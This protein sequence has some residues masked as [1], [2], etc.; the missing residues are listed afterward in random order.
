[1]NALFHSLAIF[2]DAEFLAVSETQPDPRPAVFFR[3][4]R[5]DFEGRLTFDHVDL[6]R[7]SFL[8]TDISRVDFRSLV[9]W[10][11]HEGA[12]VLADQMTLLIATNRRFALRYY[13]RYV[14]PLRPPS[15]R[16]LLGHLLRKP[17]ILRSLLSRV[18]GLIRRA[19]SRLSGWR[20][21][22]FTRWWR[23]VKLFA[24][25]DRVL[26][27]D[28]VLTEL[29]DLR[30]W[31]ERRMRYERGGRFFVS[32][33]DTRRLVDQEI[34]VD[35][36]SR[37]VRDLGTRLPQSIWGRFKAWLARRAEWTIFTFYRALCLYGESMARPL[38]WLLGTIIA[39][40]PLYMAFLPAALA[41]A[42]ASLPLVLKFWKA[43]EFSTAA[44]FQMALAE[45]LMA[46]ERLLGV[47]VNGSFL[48]A[49]R[50]KLERRVRRG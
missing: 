23:D 17:L 19:W 18:A 21:E 15:P 1:M 8:L 13:R 46:A 20:D 6:S 22:E 14:R 26:T 33:M 5:F 3:H 39:F 45:G 36:R 16:R 31:H 24:L 4:L 12:Y 2:K 35:N 44:F 47:L 41:G 37:R 40:A 27:L 11:E 48:L 42:L 34:R 49:L 30:D 38:A 28:T 9:R 7:A 50:R 32:E 29:R 25:R 10:W 43:L